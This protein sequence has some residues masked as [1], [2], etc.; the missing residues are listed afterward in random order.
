MDLDL[1]QLCGSRQPVG[2]RSDNQGAFD[3]RFN[4]AKNSE[5]FS[6]A[7]RR[8]RKDIFEEDAFIA[9]RKQSVALQASNLAVVPTTRRIDCDNLVP[10]SA[11]RTTEQDRLGVIHEIKARQMRLRERSLGRKRASP[12]V[13]SA[14]AQ[15]SSEL[16]GT[17]PSLTAFRFTS[18]IC[19]TVPNKQA[20]L[21]FGIRPSN[22]GLI[23]FQI[24]GA[25]IAC[26]PARHAQARRA[27]LALS[28][29]A[30]VIH[31]IGDF[32]ANVGQF[33]EFLFSKG[34]LLA[35]SK[36]SVSSS[37]VSQIV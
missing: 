27:N 30:L 21:S 37:L 13:H 14:E 6:L 11:T 34:I 36:L 2:N 31:V 7:A 19:N 23:S 22:S 25:C 5:P 1:D 26:L 35:C 29:H 9:G 16:G 24:V 12:E 33:Q 8:P 32:F 10:C 20:S 17:I 28:A 4:L 18:A 15:A 3:G